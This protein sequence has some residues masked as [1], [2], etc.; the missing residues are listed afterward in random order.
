[1]P[2]LVLSLILSAATV[3]HD[4]LTAPEAKPLPSSPAAMSI[5]EGTW[6]PSPLDLEVSDRLERYYSFPEQCQARI[7]HALT[8]APEP[9]VD[10]SRIATAATMGALVG[11]LSVGLLVVVAQ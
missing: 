5:P 7:D 10:W 3:N 9:A 1:M 2:V 4:L 8:V 11:A 6:L